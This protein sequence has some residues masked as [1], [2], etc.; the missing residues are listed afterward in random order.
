MIISEE[1]VLCHNCGMM[2]TDLVF[3][4]SFAFEIIQNIFVF[5]LLLPSNETEKKTPWYH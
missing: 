5:F 1:Q 3:I 2:P 4:S